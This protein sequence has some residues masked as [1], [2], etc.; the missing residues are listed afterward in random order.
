MQNPNNDGSALEKISQEKFAALDKFTEETKHADTTDR[1]KLKQKRDELAEM[2]N[3]VRRTT[4]ATSRDENRRTIRKAEGLIKDI[5]KNHL[6][7]VNKT[8]GLGLEY[9]AS[10]LQTIYESAGLL[11]ISEIYP[12]VPIVGVCIASAF[13]L[14]L[15]ARLA[16]DIDKSLLYEMHSS[17]GGGLGPAEMRKMF[18]EILD[19]KIF[20]AA[21]QKALKN[22]PATAR[23]KLLNNREFRKHVEQTLQML[24]PASPEHADQWQ[25]TKDQHEA[26]Q[27]YEEKGLDVR[28]FGKISVAAAQREFE[29]PL[30]QPGETPHDSYGIDQTIPHAINHEPTLKAIAANAANTAAQQSPG[31]AQAAIRDRLMEN[32][33]RQEYEAQIIE[34]LLPAS[35][36]EREQ[37]QGAMEGYDALQERKANQAEQGAAPARTRARQLGVEYIDPVSYLRDMRENPPTFNPVSFR[38]PAHYIPT[39]AWAAM[40][41]SSA[42]QPAAGTPNVKVI[43]EKIHEPPT[44][45]ADEDFRRCMQREINMIVNTFD[46]GMRG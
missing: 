20:I 16:D 2:L 1:V 15:L 11:A 27:E 25:S 24:L 12:I 34:K 36:T 30:L 45:L 33:A 26:L 10:D 3:D 7:P 46:T 17:R 40:A 44:R 8:P 39:A 31:Y 5:D 38:D 22:M 6:N 42:A 43:I 32:R 35:Q 4:S 23:D 41:A 14:D 21:S 13:Y 37:Y 29:P 28:K 18:L 9:I 19:R